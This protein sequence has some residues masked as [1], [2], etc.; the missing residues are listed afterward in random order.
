MTRWGLTKKSQDRELY[1]RIHT[2]FCNV[3]VYLLPG[4]TL[5]IKFTKVKS[6]FYLM[7]KDAESKSVFQ[8]LDAQLWV[9]RIRQNPI[10]PL[11][12]NAVLSK[13]GASRYNMTRVELKS[14]TFSSVSQSLSIDT[15]VLG[16]IPKRLLFTTI[17]NKYF[18]GSIDTNPYFYLQYDLQNFE[19]YVKE[20]KSLVVVVSLWTRVTRKKR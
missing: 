7:N 15:A 1:G 6:S 17:K 14:F 3:P 8:F 10:I 5:Q 9:K 20:S 2:D 16:P 12:H 11:I 4:V 19:L 13:G 18:L